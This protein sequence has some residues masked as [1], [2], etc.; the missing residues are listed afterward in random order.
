[1]L[2]ILTIMMMIVMVARWWQRWCVA[3]VVFV[4]CARF[5]ID[6]PPRFAQL[7]QKSSKTQLAGIQLHDSLEVVNVRRRHVT[8]AGFLLG[9]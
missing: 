2:V 1:V 5:A 8:S 4:A 7:I 6:V 3:V 9:A